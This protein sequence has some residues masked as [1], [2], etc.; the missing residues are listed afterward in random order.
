[1][2]GAAGTGLGSTTP[3]A[4]LMCAEVIAHTPFDAVFVDGTTE[5]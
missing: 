2:L 5:L 4:A 1:M 3:I